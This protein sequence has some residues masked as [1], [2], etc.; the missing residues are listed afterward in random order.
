MFGYPFRHGSVI[1]PGEA[2]TVLPQGSPD[3][4]T[5]L[6]RHLGRDEFA[7]ADGRGAVSLRTLDDQ[8]TACAEVGSHHPRRPLL[9]VISGP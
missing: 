8:L 2:M 1:A 6:V 7:I 9:G 4:D 3:S 5:A